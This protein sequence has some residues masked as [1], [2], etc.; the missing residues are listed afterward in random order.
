MAFPVQRIGCPRARAARP[1]ATS[2][3]GV[4]PSVFWKKKLAAS[5]QPAPTH[6]AQSDVGVATGHSGAGAPGVD[7]RDVQADSALDTAVDFLRT[8]GRY[9]IEVTGTD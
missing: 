4:R 3:T 5:S 2:R 1:A 7:L 6:E 8:F 9:A